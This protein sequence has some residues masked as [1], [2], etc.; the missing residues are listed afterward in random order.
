M[1][2]LSNGHLDCVRLRHWNFD[3]SN[4]ISYHILYHMYWHWLSNVLHH[5]LHIWNWLS[6]CLD[7]CQI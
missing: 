2:Y 4:D 3:L 1:N 7:N 6:Y 5:F